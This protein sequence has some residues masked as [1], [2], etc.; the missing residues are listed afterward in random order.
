MKK[1]KNTLEKVT[2]ENLGIDILKQAQIHSDYISAAIIN[3]KSKI[4]CEY[5]LFYYNYAD[6]YNISIADKR[7]VFFTSRPFVRRRI[8]K[9]LGKEFKKGTNEITLDKALNSEEIAKFAEMCKKHFKEVD[10]K[11][12]YLWEVE[13]GVLPEENK[14]GYEYQW[15]IEKY[16]P[17][18]Q[19]SPK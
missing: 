16:A 18:T 12:I 13:K 10:I 1:D 7:N 6:H 14:R 5:S 17:K 9:L 19:L 15:F 2:Y 8:K 4:G 3:I 11:K